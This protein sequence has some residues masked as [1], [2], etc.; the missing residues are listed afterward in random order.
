LA[1]RIS[2]EKHE[3]L[4]GQVFAMAGAN[5]KRCQIANNILAYLLQTTRPSDCEPDNSDTRLYIPAVNQH[6]YADV[7]MTCGGA[8]YQD[9]KL[10]TL[11]N[12]GLII[13]VLSPSTEA[14]DRG[15][16]FQNYRSISRFREY[17]MVTQDRMLVEHLTRVDGAKTTDWLYT[18][19]ETGDSQIPLL[20]SGVSL[21]L[22]TIYQGVAL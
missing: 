4:D 1:E 7:V 6:T 3:Y 20:V 5:R 17:L 2:E 8:Q 13:E 22:S 15:E 12:P 11:L 21:P 14:Y 9:D 10:D 16:K 18:A 19:Y